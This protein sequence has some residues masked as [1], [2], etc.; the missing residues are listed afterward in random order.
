MKVL[1]PLWA[2]HRRGEEGERVRP[3]VRPS[4]RPHG[5]VRIPRISWILDFLGV[6]GFPEFLG[7][8]GCLAFVCVSGRP[9]IDLQ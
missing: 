2:R 3:S 4:V 9:T 5:S 6:L 8:L 7:F 1:T